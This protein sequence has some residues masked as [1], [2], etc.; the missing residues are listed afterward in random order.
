MEMST[1]LENLEVAKYSLESVIELM[2]EYI[3]I[4]QEK[5]RI[6]EDKEMLEHY[7]YMLAYRQG[8]KASTQAALDLIN[9]AIRGELIK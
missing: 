6:N 3:E 2:Q 7:S 8:Q 1:L 4:D 9:Q 5:L